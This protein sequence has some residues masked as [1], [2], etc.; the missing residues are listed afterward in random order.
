[1]GKKMVGIVLTSHGLLCKEMISSAEMI[2][3][4][5]EHVWSVPLDEEGID[6]F[7]SRLCQTLDEA[8]SKCDAVVVLADIMNATPYNCSLKYMMKQA[9]NKKLHLISGYNLAAVIELLISRSFADDLE[10]LLHNI[11]DSARNSL[12][13]ASLEFEEEEDEEF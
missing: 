6:I 1:M 10:S 4:K 5:Q 3:G 11:V 2:A 8:A 12:Q 13:L 7:E 9:E